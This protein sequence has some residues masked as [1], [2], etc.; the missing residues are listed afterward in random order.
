M[1]VQ[2]KLQLVPTDS[3]AVPGKSLNVF[4]LH[5][6]LCSIIICHDSRHA[7]LV[8]LPVLHGAKLIF[9]MSWETWHDDGPVP[10]D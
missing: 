5:D 7:E 9:Y 4:K 3:F 8:R 6:V 10:L 1:C 2:A